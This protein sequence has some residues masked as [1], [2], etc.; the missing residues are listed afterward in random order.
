MTGDLCFSNTILLGFL[1]TLV[2]MGGVLVFVPMPGI[3]SMV[4][5]ARVILTFGVTIA[6]FPQWPRVTANPSVGLFTMWIIEEA[7]LGIGIGL[8]VAFAIEAFNVGAQII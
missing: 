5:P 8:L 6:L 2:R 3:T 4:H 7:A 1:L